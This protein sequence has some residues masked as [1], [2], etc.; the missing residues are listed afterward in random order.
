MFVINGNVGETTIDLN[1]SAENRYVIPL[2]SAKDNGKD[3]PYGVWRKSSKHITVERRTNDS[4]TVVCDLEAI[5]K[6]EFIVLVNYNKESAVIWFL[7]NIEASREKTYK[8]A[9]GKH[10]AKDDTV[11]LSVISKQ[12]GKSW[13]WDITYDGKPI[14][15]NTHKT[16]NK[17]VLSLRSKVADTFV[18]QVILTQQ[19]SLK[20]LIL[21]LENTTDGKV[22]VKEIR[23]AD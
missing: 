12:D 8:F 14:S 20:Q 6:E 2:K 4:I 19:K 10:T 13:P 23:E 16:Q 9:I 22:A 18:S 17:L 7:P 11:T 21:A 15:Y 1:Q 3:L 5:K